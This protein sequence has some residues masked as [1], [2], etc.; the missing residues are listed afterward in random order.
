MSNEGGYGRRA[1]FRVYCSVDFKKRVAAWAAAKGSN[2]SE[3]AI[4]AVAAAMKAAEHGEALI[5]ELCNDPH[6]AYW[7]DWYCPLPADD[8]LYTVIRAKWDGY[9]RG[10]PVRLIFEIRMDGVF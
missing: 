1:Q 2:V 5:Q 7:R 10:Y 6:G 4:E 3:A 8:A 9:R